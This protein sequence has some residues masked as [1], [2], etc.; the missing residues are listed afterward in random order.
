MVAYRIALALGCCISV[1]D[2]VWLCSVA[3]KLNW[4]NATG[5]YMVLQ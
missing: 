4:L 3:L 1:I 2:K 5:F